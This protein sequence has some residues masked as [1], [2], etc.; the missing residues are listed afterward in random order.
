MSASDQPGAS[1]IGTSSFPKFADLLKSREV[2]DPIN[3][4]INRPLAY[5]FV[6]LI[7]PLPVTPNQVTLLA[8]LTGCVA[9]ACIF[10][11]TP[12]L[13]VAGGSLVWIS[14]ILDGADGILARAKKIFSPI[15]RSIDGAGD[16]IVTVVTGFAAMW[17]LFDHGDHVVYLWIFPLWVLTFIMHVSLYD[18]HKELYLSFTRRERRGESMTM[19]KLNETISQM[20]ARHD[21]WWKLFVVKDIYLGF[22]KAQ[23]NYAKWVNPYALSLVESPLREV[24]GASE[25]YRQHNRSA[26]KAWAFISFA[27]HSYLL[28]VTAMFDRIDVYYWIRFVGMN[29]VLVVLA[30]AQRRASRRTLQALGTQKKDTP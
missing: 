1:P 26:M 4:S 2:E 29:A 28:G 6:R 17:H 18:L 13:L 9:A 14:A 22:R 7:Y 15:G 24:D 5:A 30:I 21:A 3:L 11:G 19:D 8:I 27:P 20:Q 12:A 23:L 10:I 16:A 25:V